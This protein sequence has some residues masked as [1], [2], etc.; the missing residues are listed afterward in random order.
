MADCT[1]SHF[2]VTDSP[3]E[4]VEHIRDGGTGRFGL[5]YDRPHWP[6]AKQ[7]R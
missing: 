2:S 3:A 5:G 6:D 7:P 4:A 1:R